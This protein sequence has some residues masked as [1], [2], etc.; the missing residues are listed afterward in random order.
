MLVQNKEVI[1][2]KVQ[3][4]NQL[5]RE[6]ETKIE[7]LEM[8]Q[9]RFNKRV[10]EGKVER[11]QLRA[12]FDK[13]KKQNDNLKELVKLKDQ[14]IDQQISKERDFAQEREEFEGQVKELKLTVSKREYAI[15][16]VVRTLRTHTD[17]KKR[18]EKEVE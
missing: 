14:E 3:N 13:V 4:E 11:E 15:K 9:E 1:A 8:H 10:S 12:E 16:E 6:V 7:E 5:M 17:D 2:S 18:L